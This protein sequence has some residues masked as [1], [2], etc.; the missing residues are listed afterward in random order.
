MRSQRLGERGIRGLAVRPFLLRGEV[1]VKGPAAPS[2]LG[3]AIP[4]PTGVLARDLLDG[5]GSARTLVSGGLL[6]SDANRS[7][8]TNVGRALLIFAGRRRLQSMTPSTSARPRRRQVRARAPDRAR[9]HGLGLGGAPRLA[10][11]ARRHQVHRG[12][13]RRQPG[14]AR[15]L[16]QRGARRRDDPVEARDPDLRP[17]RHRRRPPVHRHGAARRR[18]ARQAARAPSRACRSTRRRASSGRSAARSSAPTSAG[19]STAISSPRTSSSSAP[20]T[21]TTRSP[22]CST[23]ASPRSRHPRRGRRL[24]EHQ[25]GHAPRH[26]VLHVARAGARPAQRRSPDRPLV[27]RR[28]RVQVRHRRAAVRRRVA[29]RSARRRS[30]RRPSPSRRTSC[31]GCRRVRRVDAARARPRA[32]ATIPDG[33]GA[34]RRASPTRAASA[35]SAAAELADSG[36]RVLPATDGVEPGAPHDAPRS[37]AGSASRTPATTRGPSPPRRPLRSRPRRA[38]RRRS[39]SMVLSAVAAGLVGLAVSAFVVLR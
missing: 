7:R 19:S 8:P 26:A 13:V 34:L 12:G 24:L 29:R 17:R 1:H 21:T 27:A 28:H 33:A 11:H 35:C 6:E 9:R 32:R 25:D 38:R 39:K 3:S 22:R 10:R 30:A 5:A 31:P 20:R 4:A 37:S 14:G 16:R 2:G 15:A 36:S 18:A 23:S